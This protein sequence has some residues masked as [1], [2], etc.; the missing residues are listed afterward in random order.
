MSV[1]ARGGFAGLFGLIASGVS[2]ALLLG[3]NFLFETNQG[4]VLGIIAALL[5]LAVTGAALGATALGG[6]AAEPR[7]PIALF[8][9]V[10]LLLGW[11]LFVLKFVVTS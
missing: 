2:A 8:A 7:L 4:P 6:R 10:L 1:G 5:G 11:A 3:E 9:N